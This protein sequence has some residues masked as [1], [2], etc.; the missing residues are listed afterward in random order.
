MLDTYRTSKVDLH[1]PIS[2]SLL[3]AQYMWDA[4]AAW[5]CV[6]LTQV[7]RVHF[8]HFWSNL[9]LAGAAFHNYHVAQPWRDDDNEDHFL[10]RNLDLSRALAPRN[11]LEEIRA[12][13]PAAFGACCRCDRQA[14][15]SG[16]RAARSYDDADLR[17][18]GVSGGSAGLSPPCYHLLDLMTPCFARHAKAAHVAAF[19]VDRLGIF[20]LYG[21]SLSKVPR[22]VLDGDPRLSWIINNAFFAEKEANRPEGGWDPSAHN[23]SIGPGW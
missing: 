20:G 18:R 4:R 3:D 19:L 6:R 23:L 10:G 16:S 2:V 1:V 22:A 7:S 15:A 21:N 5:L 13:F 12:A 9:R 17:M 8:V 14:A 11:V